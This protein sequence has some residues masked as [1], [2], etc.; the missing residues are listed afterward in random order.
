[1]AA[2]VNPP[3]RRLA[4]AAGRPCR[5]AATVGAKLNIFILL[6]FVLLEK[7]PAVWI[8]RAPPAWRA[9]PVIARHPQSSFPGASQMPFRSGSGYFLGNPLLCISLDMYDKFDF[10]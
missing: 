4:G 5:T 6:L 1:M 8:S 7:L 10:I 3:S 2:V 9:R